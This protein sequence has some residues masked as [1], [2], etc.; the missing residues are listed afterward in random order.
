MTFNTPTTKNQMYQILQEI[1]NYYRI[2]RETSPEITLNAL[3]LTR[4]TYTPMT[5]AQRTTKA[6]TLLKAKQEEKLLEYK[7]DLSSQISELS[8]RISTCATQRTAEENNARANY[9]TAKSNLQTEAVKRGIAQS[10]AVVNKLADLDVQLANAL[11]AIASDYNGQISLYSAK[12]SLLQTRLNNADSYYT[13]VFNYEVQ[14]EKER[15]KQ[16]EEKL[17]REIF[18][19]NNGLDE[20]E[21]RAANGNL[22]A[23]RGLQLRYM[24]ISSNEFT[25]DQL[26][27]MGYYQDAINCVCAYYNTLSASTAYQQIS[28]DTKVAIY[29]DDYYSNI[30]Y[31]YQS[32][33]GT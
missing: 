3:S 11:T 27:E 5:D 29:L 32:R 6:Q 26:I 16:E 13:N 9:A 10:S 28:Q 33:A 30:L 7:T 12:R 4:M 1:F 15:I 21:Q 14:A 17:Q 23:I 25:K 24:N 19:Y 22:T 8:S 31:M 2:Q 20:K 18:K